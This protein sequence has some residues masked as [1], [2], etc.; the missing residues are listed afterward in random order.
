M[1]KFANLPI[2]FILVGL[3]LNI[4]MFFYNKVS[5]TNLMI[6]SS[7]ITILFAAAG[8]FLAS[9][10]REASIAI[11]NSTKQ[12]KSAEMNTENTGSTIDIRVNSEEDD[13]LLNLLPKAKED[14]FTEIN[15]N[16]FKK[17]MDQD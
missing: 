6:R 5:F 10:L 9:V 12:T 1:K 3:I 17:L 8:Y 11:S 2:Y 13:E 15:V 14:L 4:S 7:I 16:N